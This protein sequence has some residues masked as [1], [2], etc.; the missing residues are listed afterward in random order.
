[1]RKSRLL[2]VLLSMYVNLAAQEGEGVWIFPPGGYVQGLMQYPH[3]YFTYKS[4]Y[5]V[6]RN[7]A[8]SFNRGTLEYVFFTADQDCFYFRMGKPRIKVFWSE[9]NTEKDGF[10]SFFDRGQEYVAI[11]GGGFFATNWIPLGSNLYKKNI[12]LLT[13]IRKL[14]L[15]KRNDFSSWE[16]IDQAELLPQTI[17]RVRLSLPFLSETIKGTSV[18]YDDDM[19]LYRWFYYMFSREAYAMHFVIDPTPMV[20]GA[21][22]NGTGMT[23]DLD[24]HIP[25]DNVVVLNG[26]VDWDRRHLY[27]QN[28]RMKKILV[29]G[30]GFEFEHTFEDYVHFSQ[31]SF[32]KPVN[33]VRLTVLEV[34]DGRK[35]D[36]L[37]ISGFFTNPDIHKTKNSPLAK[38]YL[39]VVKKE[40]DEG[41]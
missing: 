41:K 8:V 35:W 11:T 24:Y 13:S 40:Y 21:P 14:M 6:N 5:N 2:I 23:I 32:P 39:R 18:I 7:Y 20:E 33:S 19:L 16:I 22:G 36:D 15:E 4:P 28:A 30:D 10:Q 17:K 31:I 1:M 3:N 9:M 38:E 27:K 37:C 26:F 25:C 34:Y 12:D 29:T